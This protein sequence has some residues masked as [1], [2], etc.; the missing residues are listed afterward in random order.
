MSDEVI[1][2][3]EPTPAPETIPEIPNLPTP[4][5]ISLPEPEPQPE[6]SSEIPK[7]EI[8]KSSEPIE[9]PEPEEEKPAPLQQST[10]SAPVE[11]P[12]PPQEIVEEK[13]AQN[14]EPIKPTHKEETAI[15][16][17]EPVDKNGMTS[18]VRSYLMGLL[19]KAN[20]AV[21]TKKQKNLKKLLT[22]FD[23]MPKVQNNDVEKFLHLKDAMATRYLNMLLKEGKIRREGTGSATR[24]YKI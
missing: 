15:Q 3:Q 13:P 6:P 7:E 9:L 4:V 5:E 19:V 18:T 14:Q 1:P 20:A 21:Q 23:T 16:K 11:E 24:Y 22:L 2:N 8:I 10:Q 12:T 17:E